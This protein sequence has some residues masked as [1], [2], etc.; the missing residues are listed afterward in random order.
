MRWALLLAEAIFLGAFV[1]R[2]L[3][4]RLHRGS[5]GLTAAV[6]RRAP[7]AWALLVLHGLLEFGDAYRDYA[8]A[9]SRFVPGV[10]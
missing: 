5:G 9:V 2:A 8:R 4:G 7:A 10:Y 1:V 6:A 3:A